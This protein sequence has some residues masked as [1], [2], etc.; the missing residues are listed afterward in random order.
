MK[1]LTLPAVALALCAPAFGAERDRGG[2]ADACEKTCAA[3]HD[4]RVI[5]CKMFKTPEQSE[6]CV[7]DARLARE[8][9]EAECRER[10][11]SEPPEE[12]ARR[13]ARDLDADREDYAPLKR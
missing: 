2:R 10:A 12:R 9:C 5:G 4:T 3:R 8:D 13:A 7:A 6:R 11:A 1:S